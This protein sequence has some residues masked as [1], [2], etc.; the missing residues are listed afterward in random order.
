LLNSRTPSKIAHQVSRCRSNIGPPCR[1]SVHD[2]ARWRGRI[3]G[4]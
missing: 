3:V 1:R 2:C 4:P